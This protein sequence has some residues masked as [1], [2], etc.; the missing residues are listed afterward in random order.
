[1]GLFINDVNRKGGGLV[2]GQS[3]RYWRYW[4]RMED[5]EGSKNLDKQWTSRITISFVLLFTCLTT[6]WV[7]GT[8]IEH[9]YWNSIRISDNS[10]KKFVRTFMQYFAMFLLRAPQYELTKKKKKKENKNEM[11]RKKSFIDTYNGC[12]MLL[13]SLTFYFWRLIS[14]TITPL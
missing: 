10:T 9:T 12:T 1:M 11:W 2:K 14:R 6:L 3:E 4:K 5:R 13:K 7:H 8:S